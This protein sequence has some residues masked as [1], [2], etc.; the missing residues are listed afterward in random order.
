MLTQT[1]N[2]MTKGRWT[3]S[4]KVVIWNKLICLFIYIFSEGLSKHRETEWHKVLEHYPAINPR[5]LTVSSLVETYHVFTPS[6]GKILWNM[7]PVKT[8]ES[9]LC[10]AHL[11]F[12]REECLCLLVYNRKHNSSFHVTVST[13]WGKGR[14]PEQNWVHAT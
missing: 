13:K 7:D 2:S 9:R 14:V 4:S 12:I 11:M 8:Q 1:Q 3:K 10:I 6:S 5:V